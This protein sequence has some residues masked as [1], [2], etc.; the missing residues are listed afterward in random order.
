M[1]TKKKQNNK[2]KEKNI[3]LAILACVFILAIIFGS[4]IINKII[5]SDN[6]NGNEQDIVDDLPSHFRVQD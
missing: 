3:I 2:L 4:I 6:T 1:S 5:N